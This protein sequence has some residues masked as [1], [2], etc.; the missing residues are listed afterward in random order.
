MQTK[1]WPSRESRRA[2]AM[3]AVNQP[4]GRAAV[5]VTAAH[6]DS[7]VL[8]MM[9]SA[10]CGNPDL[11]KKAPDRRSPH[12][13]EAPLESRHSACVILCHLERI[14]QSHCRSLGVCRDRSFVGGNV[15]G[16]HTLGGE[17]AFNRTSTSVTVKLAN[18]R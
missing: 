2:F 8:G 15:L 12:S 3:I 11:Y 17:V 16:D 1:I 5:Y 13:L 10:G 6:G 18:P 4:L 7:P 9:T 14:N